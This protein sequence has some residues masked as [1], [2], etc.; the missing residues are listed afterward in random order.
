MTQNQG[1]GD[2]KKGYSCTN[3]RW[4]GKRSLLIQDIGAQHTPTSSHGGVQDAFVSR[5]ASVVYTYFPLRTTAFLPSCKKNL[6]SKSGIRSKRKSFSALPNAQTHLSQ[7][8]NTPHTDHLVNLHLT[9]S[10][11]CVPPFSLP[12]ATSTSLFLFS[13]PSKNHKLVDTIIFPTRYAKATE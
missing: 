1:R 13:L 10:S 7:T 2:K 6:Y 12:S 3:H 8:N 4:H 9:S 5:R 11:P